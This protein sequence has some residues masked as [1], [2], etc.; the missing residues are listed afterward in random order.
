MQ[1]FIVIPSLV[2]NIKFLA[3]VIIFSSR[4]TALLTGE[5]HSLIT[6][7]WTFEIMPS[8]IST[9]LS[10]HDWQLYIQSFLSLFVIIIVIII[11]IIIITFSC[12]SG[13]YSSSSSIVISASNI[14]IVIITIV[15]VIIIIVIPIY[16]IKF[17]RYIL[18]HPFAS[19]IS[20]TRSTLSFSVQLNG[21]HQRRCSRIVN[22][23][24]WNYQIS[25]T[26]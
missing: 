12:S 9:T 15:I 5:I 20:S 1:V 23:Y 10:Q 11:I 24:C 8:W 13:S 25:E 21:S 2:Y 7:N 22:M 14:T 18:I 16:I 6:A 3:W 17:L 4:Y 26:I 19:W